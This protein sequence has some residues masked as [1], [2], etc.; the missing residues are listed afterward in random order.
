[1]TDS[2][3]A[4]LM[5]W[6]I[7]LYEDLTGTWE[8]ASNLTPLAVGKTYFLA[9]CWKETPVSHHVGFSIW[10]L[11]AGLYTSPRLCI[12]KDKKVLKK[13]GWACMEHPYRSK[14]LYRTQSQKWHMN[15]SA[16]LYSLEV[17]VPLKKR[18]W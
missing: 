13:W 1:M 17:Y 7:Q 4:P 14:S 15:I 10:L 5:K 12:P 8:Y 6:W 2:G 9:E 11:I 16:I 3:L 18:R